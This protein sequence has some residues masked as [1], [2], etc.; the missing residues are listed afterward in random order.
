MPL[1]GNQI[2]AKPN[3]LYSEKLPDGINI[4]T[5]HTLVCL[6]NGW[7]LSLILLFSSVSEKD[8]EHTTTYHS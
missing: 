5:Q 3:D 1:T 7:V 6:G 4:Y 8:S 2:I